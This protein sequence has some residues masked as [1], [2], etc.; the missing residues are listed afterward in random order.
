MGPD[1]QPPPLHLATNSAHASDR[2]SRLMRCRMGVVTNPDWG[3]K[4]MGPDSLAH[5]VCALE[6]CTP[7]SSWEPPASKRKRA[8]WATIDDTLIH[9]R[10]GLDVGSGSSAWD[11]GRSSWPHR[12]IARRS[13]ISSV[14]SLDTVG[15]LLHDLKCRSEPLPRVHVKALPT[16]HWSIVSLEHRGPGLP[17]AGDASAAWMEGTATSGQLGGGEKIPWPSI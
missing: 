1:G 4:T 13:W 5:L 7:P 9:R 15:R 11:P 16:W 8:R 12:G 10:R 2:R 14:V 6:P 17:H 3:I